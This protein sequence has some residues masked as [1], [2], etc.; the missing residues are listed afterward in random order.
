MFDPS[1]LRQLIY[2]HGTTV[3]LRKKSAGAYDVATGKV[4]QTNTDYTVKAYFFNNDLSVNEFN[5][6][7]TSERRIVVSDKLI[8]G[9]LTPEIDATDEIVFGGKTTTVIRSSIIASNGSA[10]CHLLYLRD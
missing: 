2:E 8:D 3:T 4:T 7:L 10:M 9:N 6:P 1:S 5:I